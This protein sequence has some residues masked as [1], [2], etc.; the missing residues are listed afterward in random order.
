MSTATD[1]TICLS[2]R[3]A[4]RG[5]SSNPP[6]LCGVRPP[7]SGND[8]AVG[9]RARRNH[10]AR[11]GLHI[12][13]GCFGAQVAPLGDINRDGLA[14]VGIVAS[15]EVTASHRR[16]NFRPGS[17]YVVFGRRRGGSLS[18]TSLGAPGSVSASRGGCTGSARR[19][20]GTPTAVRTLRLAASP[21]GAPGF[22][23]STG[24]ATPARSNSLNSA[25]R[26]R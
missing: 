20:I 21:A 9:V 13:A 14:D 24:A 6:G 2:A 17:A 15:G 10:A 12:P 3:P 5:V 8:R 23:S 1:W 22:G 18:M 26:A 4:S 16:P 19:V 25:R 7:W 11:G